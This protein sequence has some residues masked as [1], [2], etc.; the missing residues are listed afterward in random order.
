MTDNIEY[1]ELARRRLGEQ[2]V[3]VMPTDAIAQP[4]HLEVRW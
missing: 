1:H 2:N 3:V 4:Q